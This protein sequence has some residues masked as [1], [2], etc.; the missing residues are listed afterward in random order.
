LVIENHAARGI[1][2][3]NYKLEIT[4]QIPKTELSSQARM[5]ERE[6]S[7]RFACITH[8]FS[9]KEDWSGSCERIGMI[10]LVTAS[11]RAAECAAALT[12]AT[13]ERVVAAESLSRATTF[14]RAECYLAVVLDQY[15]L[16]ADPREADT[17]R[18]HLGTAIPVQ[19][20]LGISGTERLVREVREG[21]QRRE[22][23]EVGARKAVMG[24]VYGELNGTV[25]ALLL[26]SELAR[27]TP[28]LP[29]A[30]AEKIESVHELVKKLR[31]QL[32]SGGAEERKQA[33]GA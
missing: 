16:E 6:G 12:K 30:A 8:L 10:L 20:N 27:E 24:R 4:N 13:G 2:T 14:L 28:G 1:K 23:E 9:V 18:D 33:A 19:I 25:T 21:V 31:R 3:G 15:L 5:P 22:R 32:E 26:S 17:M 7:P 29:A 11:A